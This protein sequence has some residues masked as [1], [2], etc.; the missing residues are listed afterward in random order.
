MTQH[1]E[2]SLPDHLYRQLKQWADMRQQRVGEAIADYLADTLLQ[3]TI[4]TA[5]TEPDPEVL[6]ESEA[7]LRLQPDLWEQYPEEY[8][9]IHRG[10]L[11]DHDADKAALLQRVEQ[12]YPEHFVLVRQVRIE[13]EI[14]YESRGVAYSGA[15]LKTDHSGR[16]LDKTFMGLM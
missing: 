6:P 12:Q 3:E 14:L 4:Q 2:I 1:V 13:P 9:A 16:I 15:V 11:V 5:F 7:F 8:V 10:K